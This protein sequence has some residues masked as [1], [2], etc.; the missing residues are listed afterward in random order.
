MA[1][2]FRIKLHRKTNNIRMKLCGDFDGMSAME[3]I[4]AIKD[5]STAAKRIYIETDGLNSLLPFGLDVFQKKLSLPPAISGKLVF[6]GN[7][8]QAIAPKGTSFINLSQG[9]NS[10]SGMGRESTHYAKG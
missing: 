4:C 3:L 2:N 1:A 5:N 8:S 9:T 10:A 6:I 7:H